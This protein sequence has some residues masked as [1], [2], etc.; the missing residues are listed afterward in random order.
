MKHLVF[1]F[2]FNYLEKATECKIDF[3]YLIT[4]LLLL[5]HVNL[6]ARYGLRVCE[7]SAAETVPSAAK[8][9]ALLCAHCDII[10]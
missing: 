1:P 6:R 10:T 8:C 5:H 2:V 4:F 7:M 3:S 9:I